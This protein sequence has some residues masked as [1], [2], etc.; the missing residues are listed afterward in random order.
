MRSISAGNR[1]RAPNRA[2]AQAATPASTAMVTHQCG[3]VWCS[4]QAAATRAAVTPRGA[5]SERYRQ[6]HRA[7]STP[8]VSGNASPVLM[9]IIG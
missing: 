6:A 5:S 2:T 7:S 4:H 1:H 8:T 3:R 9:T